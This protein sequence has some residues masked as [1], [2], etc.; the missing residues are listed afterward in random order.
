M[1]R[2]DTVPAH[3]FSVRP[4]AG[5]T[6]DRRLRNVCSSRTCGPCE[7]EVGVEECREFQAPSAAT[8]KRPSRSGRAPHPWKA[9]DVRN[10]GPID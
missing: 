1:M 5:W 6:K 7:D 8:Y 4:R 10:V 9:G 2:N 3:Q